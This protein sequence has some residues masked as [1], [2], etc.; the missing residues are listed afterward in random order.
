LTV[1]NPPTIENWA[2][3]QSEPVDPALGTICCGQVI[4][5]LLAIIESRENG[6]SLHLRRTARRAAELG[7]VLGWPRHLLGD[8][9]H[10]TSLHDIGKIAVPREVLRK[11]GRLTPA[12]FGIVKSHTV[13][14]AR[15]LR[16]L[17]RPVFQLASE[18]AM[19][20]HERWDGEGYPHGL[21][22]M[23]IPF[24]ARIV[25]VVDV[26]DAL[27]ENRV[28]RPALSP[29]EAL[30]LM[31]LERGRH[32]DP[33]ILDAF[34]E[35]AQREAWCESAVTEALAEPSVEEKPALR[36]I[37]RRRPSN[38]ELSAAWSAVQPSYSP[39]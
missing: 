24:G 16:R 13:I 27:I 25:A 34:M 39:A 32:F 36:L 7:E 17:T 19:Y 3:E 33:E 5:I 15:L 2:G 20:H 8:L 14:G 37:P 31:R 38:R 28:Y 4:E 1:L 23:N 6:T 9:Q 18:I 12:E 30:D 26:F 11:E 29:D 22:G 10:S 35:L 21:K